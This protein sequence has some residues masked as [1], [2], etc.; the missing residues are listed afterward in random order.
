LNLQIFRAI[1]N[2]LEVTNYSLTFYIYC[3]FSEDFR[4]TLLRTV[5]W[6]WWG[7]K[8][9]ANGLGVG[10]S[11]KGL[12][13]SPPITQQ[14]AT[15]TPPRACTLACATSTTGAATTAVLPNNGN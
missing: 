7:E 13:G 12:K 5:N 9:P 14:T 3:L 8:A 2:V 6:P 11:A 1:A 4:S 10:P 15:P